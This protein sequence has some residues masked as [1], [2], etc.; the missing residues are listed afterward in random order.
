MM[1]SIFPPWQV[2]APG[3]ALLVAAV[4]VVVLMVPAA[5]I[6]AS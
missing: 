5:E 1:L 3:C 2:K 6:R 4:I